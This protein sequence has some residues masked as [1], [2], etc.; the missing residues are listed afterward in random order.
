MRTKHF[1]ARLKQLPD[2]APEGSVQAMFS[3]FNV[4]D[5]SRE[6]VLPSFFQDGQEVLMASWGHNWGALPVGKGIIRVTQEGAVFDGRFFLNTQSGREHYE[7]VKA[8]GDLQEWS[9]GFRVLEARP[10]QFNGEDVLFLIRGEIYEV[11][12]VLVGDNRETFTL[13]LKSVKAVRETETGVEVTETTG[14]TNVYVLG[15]VK[16]GRA[17]SSARRRQLADI[18]DNLYKSAE[19]INLILKETEP[20]PKPETEDDEAK[21]V[22]EHTA[23]KRR[24]ELEFERTRALQLGLRV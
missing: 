4:V 5:E 18:A 8:V 16:E 9:F 17:I 23:T 7:T 10:G 2:D 12:P 20:P 3:V 22:E 24:L 13:D 21:T 1:T 15:D 19:D 6:V 14:K 11:S